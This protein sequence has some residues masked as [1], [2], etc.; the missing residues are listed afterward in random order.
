M[1]EAQAAACSRMRGQPSSPFAT[2]PT[3][4][5]SPNGLL[6]NFSTTAS[7]RELAAWTLVL[8]VRPG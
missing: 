2:S 1:L 3:R 6:G 5:A 8:V 4:S 7:S